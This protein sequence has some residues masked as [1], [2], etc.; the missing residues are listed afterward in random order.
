MSYTSQSPIYWKLEPI[1][2]RSKVHIIR[3]HLHHEEDAQQY[4]GNRSYYNSCEMSAQNSNRDRGN[5]GRSTASNIHI[6]ISAHI[7]SCP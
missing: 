4:P 1:P 3:H 2:Y 5:R 6:D 7:N